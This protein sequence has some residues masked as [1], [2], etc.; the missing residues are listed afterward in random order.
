M[1]GEIVLFNEN[2]R[3]DFQKLQNYGRNKDYHIVYYVFDILRYQDQDLTV[4]PLV[5]RKKI[6]KKIL[7]KTGDVRFC[8]HIETHGEDFFKAVK[9]EDM[10]GIIAKRKESYYTPGVRTKEWLKIKN[11]KSQ[12][13]IFIK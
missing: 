1:D 5:E 2:G 11:H 12:E 7:K 4:L 3:P 6:L 9:S 13:A 10:E 8:S